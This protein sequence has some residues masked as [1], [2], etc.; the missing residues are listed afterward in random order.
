MTK[1]EGNEILRKFLE[2]EDN[3]NWQVASS[4]V[5]FDNDWELLMKVV[6]KIESIQ[7]DHHGHFQVHISGNSCTIF[8]SYLWKAIGDE[9]Y[10]HVY[11]S[12]PNAIFE[13]KR[14]STWYNVIKFIQW[15]ETDYKKDN[16]SGVNSN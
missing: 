11:L 13:T 7:D 9:N 4:M 14:E 6:E 5:N 15:Y 3:I 2:L 1:L 16:T 8:G 12:D 10:G